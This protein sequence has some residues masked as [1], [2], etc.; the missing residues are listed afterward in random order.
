MSDTSGDSGGDPAEVKPADTQPAKPEAAEPKKPDKTL[1]EVVFPA[2]ATQMMMIGIVIGLVLICGGFAA[3]VFAEGTSV[4]ANVILAIGAGVLL[5][6]FGGQASARFGPF[7]LAGVVAIT[8]FFMWWLDRAERGVAERQVSGRIAD[9]DLRRF[10]VKI[11]NDDY[12]YARSETNV[13]DFVFLERDLR[14]DTTL[15]TVAHKRGAENCP[16]HFSGPDCEL[17]LRVPKQVFDRALSG[18]KA[19]EWRFDGA[20][21]KLVDGGGQDVSIASAPIS[22]PV[23]AAAAGISL[24]PFVASAQAQDEAIENPALLQRALADLV[25]DDLDTRRFARDVLGAGPLSWVKPIADHLVANDGNY[26]I[27]LGCVVGLAQ[28][29]RSGKGGNEPD[30]RARLTDQHI[31]VLVGAA[32]DADQTMRIYASEFLV[33]LADPR[34]VMPALDLAVATG[35][36]DARLS[37]LFVVARGIT[38]LDQGGRRAAVE[39]LRALRPRANP[40]AQA[41]IDEA[42]KLAG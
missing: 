8:G 30:L 36:Q 23:Q 39:K 25:S 11:R 14:H 41:M 4:Q 35:D 12:A 26:R 22:Q 1:L 13:Y 27:E 42:L 3:K 20:N 10:D 38:L 17:V 7:V 2:Q 31:A 19:V 34:A 9:I 37:L 21:G 5:A 29:M 18:R 33:D 16:T 6:A 24:P 40:A 15:I 32:G 28:M